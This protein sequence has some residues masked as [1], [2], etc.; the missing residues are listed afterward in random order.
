MVQVNKMM[1]GYGCNRVCGGIVG[2]LITSVLIIV[3]KLEFAIF[4]QLHS[5]VAFLFGKVAF[6]SQT[7]DFATTCFFNGSET[8][9]PYQQSDKKSVDGTYV[10]V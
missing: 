5:F 2:S 7:Y 8:I 6:V 1:Y 9:E 10:F 4:L 3:G